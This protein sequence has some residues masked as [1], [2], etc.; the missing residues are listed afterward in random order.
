[1]QSE[2]QQ[3]TH[4]TI[5]KKI[6][7][8]ILLAALAGSIQAQ[9]PADMF[10]SGGEFFYGVRTGIN[11]SSVSVKNVRDFDLNSR[12]GFHVGATVGIP[13]LQGLHIQPG[14]FLTTKGARRKT[15]GSDWKEIV[16]L[17]PSYL[18]I[19]I[20]VSFHTDIAPEWNINLNI[21]PYL[22]AGLGG[23]YIEQDIDEGEEDIYK[24]PFFG[25]SSDGQYRFGARRFDAGICFGAGVTWK[26]HYYLGIQYDLGCVNMA[27]KQAWDDK[28]SLRNGTFS[29][30]LG[31]NF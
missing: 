16:K 11:V 8:S 19:P 30:Q 27:I 29:L 26:Q 18:E 24:E 10:R 2:K 5:M 9:R 12:A 21:G 22:A 1:M 6:F 23:K 13:I 17:R 20:L 3:T 31:Y 28:V 7:L 4:F 25:K 15:E 14:L